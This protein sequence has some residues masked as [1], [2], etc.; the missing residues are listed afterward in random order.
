MTSQRI[1]LTLL[2]AGLCLGACA[3]PP[4]PRELEMYEGLR[5]N[6]GVADAA[7][8][9][10]DLV[11]NADRLATKAGEHASDF[12]VHNLQYFLVAALALRIG[13][14][15]GKLHVLAPIVDTTIV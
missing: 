15:A 8:K 1:N 11:A 2:V 4:K 14:R 10:P 13:C 5:K 7:K 9:S 12:R 3:T 6:A